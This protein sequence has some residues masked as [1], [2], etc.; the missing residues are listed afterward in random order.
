[1]RGKR[2]FK[3]FKALELL[4]KADGTTIQN[5]AKELDIDQR[6]VYRLLDTMQNMGFP[7]WDE[8]IP[9][10]KK[11]QWKLEESFLL[12]LPNIKLPDFHLTFLEIILLHVLKNHSS[13]FKG[14]YIEKQIN[15]A[16][17]KINQFVPNT[18]KELTEKINNLFITKSVLPKYYKGKETIIENLIESIL[19]KKSCIIK[20]H[21]FYDDKF[22]ELNIDPLHF[23]ENRGG[24]YILSQKTGKRDIRILAV[25]RVIEVKTTQH[26]FEYPENIDPETY[27]DSLFD[28]ISGKPMFVQVWFSK[29]QARYIK[30]RTWSHTQEIHEKKDGSIVI[31]LYTS[32]WRDIKKWVL[33]YGPDA[34]I[35]QPQELIDEI[36]EDAKNIQKNYIE[37]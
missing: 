9:F 31:S 13:F 11:K 18:T 7:I 29:D 28:I 4:S 36:L 35:L 21:S 12:K 27:L 33:S 26:I 22:K 5:M 6:S 19:Q 1:M 16:F 3:I 30:E 34:K 17:F 37:K 23:F 20:Y 10:H 25:E 24:L 8:K 14:T 32:G 15:S 2:I